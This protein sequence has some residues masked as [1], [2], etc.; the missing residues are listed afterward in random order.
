[1]FTLVTPYPAK[2][3]TLR[4]VLRTA[5][6]AVLLPLSGCSAAGDSGSNGPRVLGQPG[7]SQTGS[8]AGSNANGTGGMGDFG[9]AT[10]SPM[11]SPVAAPIAGSGAPSVP[12]QECGAVTQ[13]A[14][15]TLQPADII[16][17][18]DTSGSM[19]EEVAE[20]QANLNAFSQQI[21]DSG[22]DVRVIV[23][24]T[25]QGSAMPGGVTV[26]GP[27]IAAPLGSGQCPDD[28]NPPTYVHVNQMVAS[29]DVLDI[30]VN[31]YP[32]YKPHLREGSLKTFVTITD[33]NADSETSPFGLLG[34]RPTIH[35][36][37]DFIAAVGNLEPGSPMWSDWR[38]SGIYSFTLCES[39][40]FG[41]VGA[42]HE[43]LVAKTGGVKGDLCLQQFAPVFDE[44][45]KQVAATVTLACD[46]AI[47]PPPQ[48]ETFDKS[49]S[50]V[51]VTLDGAV[52]QLL[53][54]PDVS[55]CAAI[56]GWH[57]DDEAAPTKVVACPSTCSRIQAAVD[58]QVDLQFGCETLLVP[59]L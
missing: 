53:K 47:P 58:A 8:A 9:N 18:I 26:D 33:D 23:L 43:A 54:V 28:S 31:A 40:A 36:A 46:W 10:G 48:G 51:Q 49:K 11:G 4:P 56:E 57:Y 1:M 19:S 42:V 20:V 38:Y 50:N 17:G 22:I 13:R 15:N 29:W 32:T 44:L 3:S 7:G 2:S 12:G 59:V 27:C 5:L 16:F 55:Q 6:A 25:P 37:D 30:Y 41:A 14:E 45:A 21:I 52:E 39:A 35:T 34:V 24:A